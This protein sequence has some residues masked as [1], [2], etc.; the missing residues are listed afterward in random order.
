VRTESFETS[1]G[2]P[3]ADRVAAPA[4]QRVPARPTRH[5]RETAPLDRALRAAVGKAT[6][7]MSP[8]AIAAAAFDWGSHIAR[9]PVRQLDLLQ[10]AWR[11]GWQAWVGSLL[12]G[13]P[14]ALQPKPQDRRFDDPAW[15]SAPYRSFMQA[16]L[17]AE[18]W[19]EEATQP[20]RGMA[21]RHSERLA[22][23]ARTNLSALSPSNNPWL[24]PVV[25]AA[26]REQGGENLRRGWLNLLEDLQHAMAPDAKAADPVGVTLATTPGAVV[27]RNHLFELI[28]Y[29]PT[30]DTVAREPVLIT[31][32][33][34]MKYYILDLAP[35]TSLVRYLRDQGH[36]VFMM[37]WRNPTQA[38]QA[39]TFDAYRTA[40]VMAAIDAV[41]AITGVN[42]IHL[43]GYCLGG[44]IATIAAAT[45]AREGDSRLA[46]LTLFA[47]Q[48]DFSEAGELMLL[49]DEAQ[50]AF[51]E[52]IM[53]D[54]GLLTGE[55]MAAA[56]QL[57]RADELIWG[58]MIREYVLGTRDSETDLTIWNA[59]L[60]NM[61]ATMHS[62]YLRGLFLENRLTAGRYAVDGRVVALKDIEVP[63]FVVGTETDHIAPWRSVYKITLFTDT[64]VTFV[65]TNGGHNAGIVA[66]PG[67]PKRH[68][69]FGVRA[70]G[71]RYLDPD[72][73]AEQATPAEGS[74]WPAWSAW[75]HANSSG[76]LP[77]P[78]PQDQ[79]NSR[80]P[81]LDAAPGRYVRD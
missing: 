59:D 71:D 18:A 5:T 45:M 12:P 42:R 35:E 66:R 61:P 8:H 1:G 49:V 78:D 60:T 9:S 33:W 29:A 19:A 58:R 25:N 69:R 53:W 56:F 76:A 26:T 73:W 32:A 3:Q 6:L 48:T 34:I 36:R 28:D 24:N 74:W 81:V 64:D 41:E 39:L 75:L 77:A 51:L 55:Q 63:M 31:P 23:L 4:P 14:V 21:G 16:Q 70:S 2:A 20:M 57:L 50:V 38:D 72:S 65:L 67:H 44:T 11:L 37:S 68:Y 47:A 46:S 62:E 27:F 13:E 40:G 52:D 15:Q 30:T 17:A 43:C 10:S 79:A 80:Y 22:L 7:G 54:Q